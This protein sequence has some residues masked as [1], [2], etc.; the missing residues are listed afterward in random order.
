MLVPDIY[1]KNKS[2]KA[3]WVQRM[4]KQEVKW[5]VFISSNIPI[6]LD[7]FWKCNLNEYDA[8]QLINNIPNRL[9]KEII[10]SWFEYSHHEPCNK[11]AYI[12]K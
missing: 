6:N 3:A 4:S 7:L 9:V 2:L 12:I 5:K 8:T 11:L 1:L 10:I